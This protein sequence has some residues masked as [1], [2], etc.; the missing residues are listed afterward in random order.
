[1]G[2]FPSHHDAI[3]CQPWDHARATLRS[4]CAGHGIIPT[5]AW[6][7]VVPVMRSFPT[8]HRAMSCP[9][10]GHPHLTIGS[11]RACHEVIPTSPWGHVVP[12]MTPPDPEMRQ[13]VPI[14]PVFAAKRHLVATVCH[15]RRLKRAAG[16]PHLHPP[17]PTDLLLPSTAFTNVPKARLNGFP[18]RLR[19]PEA[20]QAVPQT[21]HSANHLHR[22]VH[23]PQPSHQ[24]S[25]MTTD[26][27]E[28]EQLTAI[29]GSRR[30]SV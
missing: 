5:S 16:P 8:R 28:Y 2:S 24:A 17:P 26:A 7:H 19:N 20:A 12:T 25:V 22:E 29:P 21:V 11:C 3:P 30:I 9:P 13:N 10:W 1:M 23:F 18:V 27:L 14:L 15:R 6:G 4:C